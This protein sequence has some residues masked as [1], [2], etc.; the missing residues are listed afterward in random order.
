MDWLVGLQFPCQQPMQHRYGIAETPEYR[1]T[2][3][4]SAA[5]MT[6]NWQSHASGGPLGYTELL[7]RSEVMP[8][9]LRDDWKRNWGEI[10]RLVPYD[11]AATAAL[12]VTTTVRRSGIWN[13]G[14][15]N[16]AIR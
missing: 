4:F 6:T 16:F 1:I 3:E 10:H 11:P 8:S 9:Y 14:P 12:P 7:A 13:P 5:I 15:L 2:P